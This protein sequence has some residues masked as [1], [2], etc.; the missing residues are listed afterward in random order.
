MKNINFEILSRVIKMS[1]INK[2]FEIRN[3][4]SKV[5]KTI[6]LKPFYKELVSFM[7]RE[8]ISN[9]LQLSK[10]LVRFYKIPTKYFIQNFLD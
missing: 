10:F 1:E 2:N 8:N 5:L 3:F 4:L 7:N 9:N 6:S